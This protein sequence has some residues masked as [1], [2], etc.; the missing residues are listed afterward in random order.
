MVEEAKNPG[1]EVIN[2]CNKIKQCGHN[3][4]GIKGEPECI[5]CMSEECK[6]ETMIE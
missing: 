1:Q 3:C 5:P 6:A 2:Y 4:D